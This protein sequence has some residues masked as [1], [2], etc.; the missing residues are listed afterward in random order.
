MKPLGKLPITLKAGVHTYTDV[1][2]IYPNVTTTLI[3]WKAAR[4]LTIL[5]RCYPNPIANSAPK[6]N[7]PAFQHLAAVTSNQPTT[8]L[9]I[10]SEFLSVFD[11][12]IKTMEGETFHIA[13]TKDAKPFCVNTPRTVPFAYREKLQAELE[14]LQEQGIIASVTEPTEWCSPIVVAP[15]KDSDKIR[16]CVDL[17][18]LNKYVKRERYQ[19]ATPAQAVADIAAQSAKVFTKLDALKGYHQCPL[20]PC[21]QLLT[22][23]ITPSIS[24]RPLWY[25]LHLGTLQ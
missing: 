7:Q 13:L 25:I 21:S 11:G 15:K 9:D 1:F 14:L 4:G 19:S 10:R 24:A 23:F 8:S 3:S 18:Q 17:S 22:T 16:L 6:T 2:H 12:Q 20:D 5:P